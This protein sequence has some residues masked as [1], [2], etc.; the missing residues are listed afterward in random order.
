MTF[1]HFCIPQIMRCSNS[2]FRKVFLPSILNICVRHEISLLSRTLHL[3]SMEKKLGFINFP[4]S[5]SS[6]LSA[7]SYPIPCPSSVARWCSG[8]GVGLVIDRSR[9]RLPVGPLPGSPAF[10][11]FGVGK[12]STSLLAGVKAGVFTCV[13]W[14][15]TLCD[16]IWQVM[17]RS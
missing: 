6:P 11:A 7:L 15:V 9:I 17:P 13:G 8:L 4:P 14:Q 1:P 10:H 12:S 3:Q 5:P 16:P 2:A